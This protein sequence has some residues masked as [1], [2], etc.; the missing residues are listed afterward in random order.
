MKSYQEYEGTAYLA[1]SLREE[2]YAVVAN[3]EASGTLSPFIRDNANDRMANAGVQ[4]M[5]KVSIVMELMRSWTDT[6]G[7][8][9]VLQ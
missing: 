2:G 6:P 5:S 9:E 4:I 7:G 1:L 3:A 8:R